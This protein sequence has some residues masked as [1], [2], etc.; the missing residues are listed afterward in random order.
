MSK[1]I[2]WEKQYWFRVK[3][4]GRKRFIWRDHVIASFLV[5]LTMALG[6]D[7][8]RDNAPSFS[9][10]KLVFIDLFSLPIF[11]LGGYLNGGWRWK[12]LIKKYS[13]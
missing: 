12:Q 9:A 10:S 6:L 11:L 4:A 5:W 3:P 2:E 8:F 7:L 1:W 13:Q